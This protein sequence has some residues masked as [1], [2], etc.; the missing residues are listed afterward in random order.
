MRASISELQSN[1]S[2]IRE[3]AHTVAGVARSRKVWVQFDLPFPT[4]PNTID[5]GIDIT[6]V[7]RIN[8]KVSRDK[9]SEREIEQE[10]NR[11][12]D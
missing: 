2:T 3:E 10:S 8:D 7:L 5:I 11:A 4:K 6:D 12:K 9:E 1:I